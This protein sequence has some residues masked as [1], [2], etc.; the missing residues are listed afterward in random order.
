[1]DINELLTYARENDC[2]DIHI[3]VGTHLAL[4]RFG[5][6]TFLEDIPTREEAEAMIMYFLSEEE[7]NYVRAG[8]DIDVGYRLPDRSR[9]R[10]N[11]YRQRDNLAASIR[12]L[13]QKIPT[14]QELGMPPVLEKFATLPRG[15]VLVTGPTGCGKSTTLASMMQLINEKYDRHIMTIE[16]PI[17]YVLDHKKALIHQREVGRDVEDFH[18]ALRSA[19]REDPD[20]IMV[21]E[22]RDYQTIKAAIAAAE[23]GHLVFSTLHTTSA[24][25]TIERIIDST[26]VD[27]Q[28]QIRI[29]LASVL[30]GVVTQTLIPKK[31]GDG[32]VA[33]TEVMAMNYAI[34][35]QVRD[36]KLYVI[37]DAIQSG[38]KEQMHT[39]NKDLA[40]LFKENKITRDNAF[41]FSYNARELQHLL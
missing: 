31:D 17:E 19:L 38:S 29:Q 36:N 14:L 2:S 39:L 15:M 3:T 13:Y 4:R 18:T 5:R 30:E 41:R 34:R 28:Q 6:L 33:A 1:M 7:K 22:M 12:M 8:H 24:A 32:L 16:D 9:V 23:T 37:P 21:G 35:N 26:P 20:I 27:N 11:V 25:Q 10:V 40:R